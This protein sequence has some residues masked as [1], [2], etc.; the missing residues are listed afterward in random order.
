MNFI[1][2][3]R[4][5]LDLE[6]ESEEDED[7]I[8]KRRRELRQAIVDKYQQSLPSTPM[9]TSPAPPT[10]EETDAA[11][12]VI[13]EELKEEGRRLVEAE[14]DEEKTSGLKKE[15]PK[16]DEKEQ[17]EL[18]KKK[19]NLKALRASVRN[20]DM[21]SDEYLFTEVQLVSGHQCCWFVFI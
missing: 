19:T 16:E 4:R 11:E 12:K 21:F 15:D 8:I 3:Y 18:M 9:V 1:L 20:G 10:Q 7:A 6:P 17:D 2:Y 13:E 5:V 14:G